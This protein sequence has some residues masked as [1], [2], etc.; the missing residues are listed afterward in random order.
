MKI[1]CA[2]EFAEV[3]V[4]FVSLVFHASDTDAAFI[5]AH[6]LI[7]STNIIVMSWMVKTQFLLGALVLEILFDKTYVVLSLNLD[8]PQDAFGH[9]ALL[10]PAMMIV[11]AQ[12]GFRKVSRKK[13]RGGCIS[14]KKMSSGDCSLYFAWP[15]FRNPFP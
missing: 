2:F 5:L 8:A 4:Q 14:W 12:D 1:F 6:A 10:F 7:L 15:F 11:T 13:K 3:V 9:L